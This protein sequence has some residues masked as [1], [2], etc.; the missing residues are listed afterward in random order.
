MRLQT[1]SWSEAECP[2]RCA[3]VASNPAHY[4]PSPSALPITA[5]LQYDAMVEE[6]TL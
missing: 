6:T 1:R 5:H 2:A 3:H 4:S